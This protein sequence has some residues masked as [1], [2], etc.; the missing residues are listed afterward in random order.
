MEEESNLNLRNCH[1]FPICTDINVT[2]ESKANYFSLAV[3]A[4]FGY[5]MTG[6]MVM[7][8]FM[9]KCSS[10]IFSTVK[11]GTIF[12]FPGIVKGFEDPHTYIGASKLKMCGKQW[13]P[14]I[15]TSHAGSATLHSQLCEIIGEDSSN[16]IGF[17]CKYPV[18]GRG[19]I[20][21]NST[22]CN[23][24]WFDQRELPTNCNGLNWQELISSSLKYQLR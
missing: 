13:D 1:N 9:S 10:G 7:E 14:L 16:F 19:N 6:L 12:L 21:Y 22:T 17:S 20:G 11:K 4:R 3:N 18:D 23:I 5:G 15:T 2:R 8:N 24:H